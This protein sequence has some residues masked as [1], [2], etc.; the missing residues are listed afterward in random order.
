MIR[1]IVILLVVLALPL[2]SRTPRALAAPS[3]DAL[4]QKKPAALYGTWRWT[5]SFGGMLPGR[6][7]PGA[8]GCERLMLLKQDGS[9]ELV[10]QDSVHEY[11]LS[12]GGST[13]TPV[14]GLRAEPGWTADFA[15]RLE[16]WWERYETEFLIRLDGGDSLR[17][18]PGGRDHGVSDAV[19]HRFVR[20]SPVAKL[21]AKK[22]RLPLRERPTRS[23]MEI[24]PRTDLAYVEEPPVPT[25]EVRATWPRDFEGSIVGSVVLRVL[26]GEDGS[27]K[28]VQ[29]V[30]GIRGLNEAA[31]EAARHW[32]FK[33]ARGSNGKPIA[34]WIDLRTIW[35][36]P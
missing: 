27:V 10:E 6:R 3:P 24:F 26:V 31:V 15:V 35:Q 14:T 23:D 16:N 11:V 17:M 8:C 30:R 7:T 5:E 19:E 9:Y 33:P 13:I 1:V 20:I 4:V 2:S 21:P 12:S 32:E 29:I 22:I 34:A 28:D 18:Y 36:F 25:R